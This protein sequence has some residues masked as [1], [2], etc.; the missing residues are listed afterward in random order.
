M[1]VGLRPELSRT[2]LALGHN[3]ARS[4]KGRCPMGCSPD[5][6]SAALVAWGIGIPWIP[7]HAHALRQAHLVSNDTYSD[8]FPSGK[9]LEATSL[10]N[11]VGR[12]GSVLRILNLGGSSPLTRLR[13]LDRSSLPLEMPRSS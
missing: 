11:L 13:L 6:P 12:T 9:Y 2:A 8:L 5:G 3:A 7:R 4:E 1:P 10:L